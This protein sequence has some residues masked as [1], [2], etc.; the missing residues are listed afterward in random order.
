MSGPGVNSTLMWCP[1]S[2][3]PRLRLSCPSAWLMCLPSHSGTPGS[4][5]NHWSW[6]PLRRG[7][8]RSG[9]RASKRW[10]TSRT[11]VMHRACTLVAVA[12]GTRGSKDLPFGAGGGAGASTTFDDVRGL[13]VTRM[14]RGGLLGLLAGGSLFRASFRV[15][16]PVPVSFG[17][18][19][20][21]LGGDGEPT[22]LLS[23]FGS[24][25]TRAKLPRGSGDATRLAS[26]RKAETAVRL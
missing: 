13:G 4:I 19:I 25:L 5:L 23:P 17:S 18:L 15:P 22:S 9:I 16:L 20:R 26:V 8:W 24:A 2:P 11:P 14:D 12:V 7:L 3:S 10:P 1:C 21:T 6:W